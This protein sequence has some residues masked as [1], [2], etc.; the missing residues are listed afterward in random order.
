MP[1]FADGTRLCWVYQV[2]PVYAGIYRDRGDPETVVDQVSLGRK[3]LG[4]LW[5]KGCTCF[6]YLPES[7]A[8]CKKICRPL[9]QNVQFLSRRLLALRNDTVS[10]HPDCKYP[11]LVQIRRLKPTGKQKDGVVVTFDVSFGQ[12]NDHWMR[13]LIDA[14]PTTYEETMPETVDEEN[15]RLDSLV[16]SSVKSSSVQQPMSE[17]SSAPCATDTSK[18]KR[19]RRSGVESSSAS[20]EPIHVSEA[21]L[22]PR[23]PVTPSVTDA[24]K[25]RKRTDSIQELYPKRLLFSEVTSQKSGRGQLTAHGEPNLSLDWTSEHEGKSR[26]GQCVSPSASRSTPNANQSDSP[27]SN[28]CRRRL[29]SAEISSTGKPAS[30]NEETTEGSYLSLPMPSGS[31]QESGYISLS[32]QEETQYADWTVDN[33]VRRR[34]DALSVEEWR[35]LRGPSS[36]SARSFRETLIDLVVQKNEEKHSQEPLWLPDILKDTTLG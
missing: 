2:T 20:V 35:A 26:L 30:Q 32:M 7:I 36:Q 1:N 11:D 14:V 5:W 22:P 25:K 21:S 24:S 28:S 12:G 19:K 16:C 4:T 17:A 15:Q 9:R 3:Q 10:V 31:D 18:K 13:F 29:W 6:A 34:C 23:Q 33:P 27:S 8:V